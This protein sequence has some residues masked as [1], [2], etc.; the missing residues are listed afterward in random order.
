[1]IF[2]KWYI[3]ILRLQSNNLIGAPPTGV[4]VDVCWC[5]V[6]AASGDLTPQLREKI[7]AAWSSR[8]GA[9]Y[10]IIVSLSHTTDLY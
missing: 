9:K 8:L 3:G 4:N 5:Q 2:L 10:K 1:M 7:E 6:P